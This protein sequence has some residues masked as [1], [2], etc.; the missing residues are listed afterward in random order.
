MPSVNKQDA[1]KRQMSKT[2]TKCIAITLN[3]GINK[4]QDHLKA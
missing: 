2:V 4:S 3:V 1:D